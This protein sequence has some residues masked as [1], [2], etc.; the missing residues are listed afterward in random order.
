MNKEAAVKNERNNIIW[1][2]ISILSLILSIIAICRLFYRTADLGFDY[3][4]VI[5]G[6]LAIMV[7]YLVAWNIHTAIDANHKIK[8]MRDEIATLRSTIVSDKLSSERKVN[9]L[10]AEL[11]DN[12][13]SIN[14]HILGF[15]KTTV[16]TH[17]LIYMVSSI[18]YLSRSEEYAVAESQ[19]DYYY[20]MTKDHLALIKKDLD[21]ESHVGLYRLLYEI[22][23]KEK[24]KNFSKLEELIKLSCS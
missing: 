1:K 15:E 16:S 23:N 22:P 2:I 11:Y 5:V 14:R 12:I 8:E 17:L 9:K 21:K 6:S 7:T 18:D 3:L 24:I 20:V 10:K 4:G 19:I 13:V